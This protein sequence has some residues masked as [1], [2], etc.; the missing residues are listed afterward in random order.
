MARHN[1][2]VSP[3]V[4]RLPLSDGDWIEVKERLSYAEQEQLNASSMKPVIVQEG[5]SRL[6][7]S[8][9]VFNIN[10]VAAWVVDWSFVGPD[11]RVVPVT[12]AYIEALDPATAAEITTALDAHVAALAD[13]AADPI[14]EP[15][16]ELNLS[17]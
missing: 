15:S 9:E 2:F 17:S 11:D 8:L 14:G 7:L 12:R 16:G 1:R 10:R 13:L 6:E 4:V 5:G 3:N